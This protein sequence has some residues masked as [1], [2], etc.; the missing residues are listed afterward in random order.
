MH[1]EV[2]IGNL[3]KLQ[4]AIIN[5][6]MRL[7]LIICHKKEVHSS[8]SSIKL[9]LIRDKCYLCKLVCT[10]TMNEWCKILTIKTLTEVNR[11]KRKLF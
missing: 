5:R 11:T 7:Q 1:N 10:D 9:V 6:P 2:T 4:T 8:L 3:W